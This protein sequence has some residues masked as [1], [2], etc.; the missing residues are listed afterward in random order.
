MMNRTAIAAPALAL[1]L[2]A[3]AFAQIGGVAPGQLFQEI[4]G[5]MEFMGSLIA[6]PINAAG[7]ERIQML[8]TDRIDQIGLYVIDVPL[9]ETENS[10]AARLIATGDYE[11]VEP[12]RRLLH[13]ITPNDSQFNQQWHHPMMN[14]TDAW[15]ITTG[16]ASVVVAIVDSGVDLDHPDLE[17]RLV[18]GF[19]SVTDTAQVNG[20]GVG[21]L[22]GHGSACAG[23]A[24]AIG[25]QAINMF[26]ID[27]VVAYDG[28]RQREFITGERDGQLEWL[29][30]VAA[31]M[32]GRSP[33]ENDLETP[34]SIARSIAQTL[35]VVIAVVAAATAIIIVIRRVRRRRQRSEATLLPTRDYTEALKLLRRAGLEKPA[36]RPPLAHAARIEPAAPL[37]AAAFGDIAERLYALNLD[38]S[39]EAPA[40]SGALATLRTALRKEA[41]RRA[42]PTR[43]RAPA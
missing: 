1:F 18:P 22:N 6:K 43:R 33:F 3:P 4:P 15:D 27:T 28:D 2:S 35:A 36:G 32:E 25:N 38:S 42:A 17:D 23:S 16:D 12:N 20:G 30:R 9:G 19:N 34:A 40:H 7:V 31:M 14:S 8:T 11:Y 21:D 37:S 10:L 41:P 39:G 24:A 13:A 26:W 29:N 5:N